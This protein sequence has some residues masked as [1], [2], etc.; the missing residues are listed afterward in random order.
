MKLVFFL[1]AITL[2]VGCFWGCEDAPKNDSIQPVDYKAWTLELLD[3]KKE[4]CLRLDSVYS[5]WIDCAEKN[6]LLEN[7]DLLDDRVRD[8]LRSCAHQTACDSIYEVLVEKCDTTVDYYFSE[9]LL[10]YLDSHKGT[11]ASF[12]ADSLIINCHWDKVRVKRTNN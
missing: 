5:L 8:S 4:A 10:I 3:E 9:K 12:D 7:Y 6:R 11:D 2:L 1:L